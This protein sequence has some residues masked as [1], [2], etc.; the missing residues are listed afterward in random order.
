MD[1]QCLEELKQQVRL[2]EY[3]KQHNWEP[4][5]RSTGPQVGGL[6]PLHAETR[7]SFWIHTAKNLFYC[8][9]CGQGGDVIR[10]VQLLHGVSFPDALR[11]LHGWLGQRNPVAAAARFYGRQ[12]P[13]WPEAMD[14][15]AARGI[16]DR[17]TI[18]ALQTGYA[19]GACLHAHLGQLGYSAAQM[20]NAGLI[21]E[22]GRDAWRRRLVFPCGENLYSRRIEDPAQ[23]RFLCGSKGGLYHWQA[24]ERSPNV[25][26]VE[27]M[28]DLAALWQAGFPATT[29]GWGTHL[30]REQYAQLA[31][32]RRTVWIA[33]DGDEGGQRAAQRLCRQLRADGQPALRVPVPEGHDPASYFAG[34]ATSADFHD[35]LTEARP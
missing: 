24:M 29:C 11:Q 35:L 14:Y 31:R 1:R 3:L 23:H 15:L 5:R 2:L 27:G 21:D 16:R 10:L 22:Q 9:G 12:L 6:C 7:P 34:G 28:F 19:P 17:D 8:H 25:I 18:R 13:R 20:R 30:N 33:F 4:C 32:G 26:L